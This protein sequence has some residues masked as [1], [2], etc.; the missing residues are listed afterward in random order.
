MGLSKIGQL[1]NG[2]FLSMRPIKM[3]HRKITSGDS[4]SRKSKFLQSPDQFKF[5]DAL[6]NSVNVFLSLTYCY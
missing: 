5:P 4:V 1:A 6:R 2:M 3:G